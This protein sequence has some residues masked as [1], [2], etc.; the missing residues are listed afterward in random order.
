MNLIFVIFWAVF[1]KASKALVKCNGTVTKLQLCSLAQKYEQ[2][3]PIQCKVCD[4]LKVLTSVTVFKI[5][6]L[7]ENKNTITLNALLSVWW[8]DTR[9]TLETNHLNE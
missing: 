6:E 9:V 1:V 8:N 4:P 3:T 7:D 2:G 5:A